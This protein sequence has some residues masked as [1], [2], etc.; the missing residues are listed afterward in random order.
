ML[1][2]FQVFQGRCLLLLEFLKPENKK[3]QVYMEFCCR[4]LSSTQRVLR[5][6]TWKGK[7]KCWNSSIS[8]L[9][10]KGRFVLKIFCWVH[11]DFCGLL[12]QSS[13]RLAK[14]LFLRW[15]FGRLSRYQVCSEGTTFDLKNCFSHVWIPFGD[16]LNAAVGV[17]L[18]LY[19][20]LEQPLWEIPVF[21]VRLVKYCHSCE[22]TFLVAF[23]IISAQWEYTV[24]PGWVNAFEISW[25]FK[26]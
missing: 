10:S 13:F 21:E 26:R 7:C 20:C 25:I 24:L 1:S 8:Y 12:A 18:S 6:C 16:K 4:V 23:W 11:E 3:Y 19:D 9:L 17:F 22:I 5:S 2:A 15:L 14:K